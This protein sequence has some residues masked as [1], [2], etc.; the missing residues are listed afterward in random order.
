MRSFAL[1]ALTVAAFVASLGFA[2]PAAAAVTPVRL[3]L[4]ALVCNDPNEGVDEAILRIGGVDVFGPAKIRRNESLDL[5]G[6]PLRTF[7]RN[8]NVT[9]IEDD[10]FLRGADD[11]LGTVT[12]SRDDL[13]EGTRQASFTQGGA[14]YTLFYRVVA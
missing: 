13:D 12:I 9:L 4:I 10:G 8:V 6:L 1:V 3:E 2:S 11:F 14:N 5:Q 7:R